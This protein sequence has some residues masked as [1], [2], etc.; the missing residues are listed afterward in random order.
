MKRVIITLIALFATSATADDTGL[1]IGFG[2]AAIG[3]E[4]CFDSLLLTQ[5]MAE[6]KFLL[7]LATHGDGHC[8]EQDVRANMGIG[9][10]RT[11]Q[12]GRW[13]FGFGGGVFEHGDRGV[14]PKIDGDRPQLCAQILIR[15]Y[16]L[17]ERAVFDILHCSTG[18]S[19]HYNPGKNWAVLGV[20]F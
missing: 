19:T 13:S 14:G 15:R 9:V 18:G 17:K 6:R 1:S 8:R 5:E 12:L 4:A 20:R 2:K 10:L 16:L 3:S 11:T 7:T